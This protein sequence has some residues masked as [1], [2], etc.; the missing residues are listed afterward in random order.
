MDVQRTS[1]QELSG[2]SKIYVYVHFG[3]E[4]N[5]GNHCKSKLHLKLTFNYYMKY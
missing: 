5:H 1:N 2:K 4:N 3:S